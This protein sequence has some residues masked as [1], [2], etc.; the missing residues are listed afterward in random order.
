MPALRKLS[1]AAPLV[2]LALSGCFGAAAEAP[3]GPAL[4][5]A[6]VDG[7]MVE[8][9]AGTPVRERFRLGSYGVAFGP[10]RGVVERALFVD[11]AVRAELSGLVSAYGPFDLA[12]GTSRVRFRGRGALPAPSPERRRIAEWTRF[13]AAQSTGFAGSR[14]APVL[15][16][17]R[18]GEGEDCAGLGI[19]RIGVVRG[20]PCAVGGGAPR[21]L[22]SAE[23]ERL[24]AWFDRLGPFEVSWL[25][26]PPGEQRR[27]RL[28]FAGA[29]K[30]SA[31]AA[32]RD[33]IAAF[34]A[35]L[36][37]EVPLAGSVWFTAPL[38]GAP[39]TSPLVLPLQ[40]PV[41]PR[42]E[43]AFPAAARTSPSS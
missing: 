16:W 18:G 6:P 15:F 40:A 22:A 28:V 29:G 11:D 27:L 13:V 26:G 31:S 1:L 14:P 21:R 41:P 24:Y 43:M 10:P 4:G 38:G 37:A 25:E 19:D 30:G 20:G 33:E 42:M 35:T 39:H 2:A 34:A 7:T 3:D 32:A 12:V 17:Q 5:L 9:L 36:A 23:L 8:I